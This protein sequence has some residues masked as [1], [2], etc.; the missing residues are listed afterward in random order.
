MG[1]DRA[2][3]RTEKADIVIYLADGAAH[4][5]PIVY[6]VGKAEA[7]GEVE[8]IHLLAAVGAGSDARNLRVAEEGYVR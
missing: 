5:S 6:L 4:N 1:K 3:K 2:E 7:S 8:I